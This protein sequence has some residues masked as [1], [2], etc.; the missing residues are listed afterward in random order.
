[1]K[2]LI[3][4]TP[5]QAT[6]NVGSNGLG[7]HIYDFIEQ[8]VKQK[9]DVTTIL[10]E[11]S[12]LEWDTVKQENFTELPT[13]NKI[14]KFILDNKFD[15]VLDNSHFHT[16]SKT[17]PE[18]PVVNFIH[19]EECKYMPTNTILGNKHQLESYPKG[20]VFRTGINFD[21]YSLY[22]LKKDYY[23]FCGKIERR[24]GWD[25]ALSATQRCKIKTIFAG[26]NTEG[27]A[28]NI[29]N[30]IGEIRDHKRFCEFV[31]NSK[32][33]FYPSRAD[34]G[35][36]GIWEAAALGTPTL[37]TA[38]SG[39]RCNVIHGKTGYVASSF[40]E[41]CE[42]VNKVSDLDPKQIREEARLIWDLN[43]NFKNIF[44]Q[45]EDFCNGER[46]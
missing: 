7:R 30:W 5:R 16:L 20:R 23:S 34:A 10:H 22:P 12:K 38:D 13:L 11:D 40:D 8:F 29:P 2:I 36:M 1:M 37:T 25:L 31:G 14:Y 28:Q 33:L 24:K 4:G 32:G 18:L 17:Y 43:H 44:K 39:A 3:I 41:L 42:S 19:D 6:L 45:L 26:P 27:F 15:V 35:G 21:K 46:W 9:C